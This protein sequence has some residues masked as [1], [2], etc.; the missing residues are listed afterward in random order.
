MYH[1]IA[2]I[3]MSMIFVNLLIWF[4]FMPWYV[5]RKISRIQNDIV[6]RHYDE[7]KMTYQNMRGW[8]HDFHNHVQ[9][10][11]AH[12]SLGQYEEAKE[13]LNGLERDLS[14]IDTT[15]KTGNVTA[16]A[17]LNS[18]LTMMKAR[19]IRVD[20]TAAVPED[21]AISGTDLCILIGNMLDNAIEACMKMP[22]EERYIRIYI[23]IIKKQFYIVVTNSMEGRARRE[24]NRYI[25]SKNTDG[26]GFGLLRIDR[27][28]E[29]YHGYLNRKNE[30]GVF[31]TEVMLPLNH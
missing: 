31:A 10:L 11:K 26:H 25:S 17:I 27:V 19:A 9:T 5:D 20:A 23:D 30:N 28:V 24:G 18:K 7:V 13:Y 12:M 14:V 16:D 4:I 22:E 6:N 29:K 2:A 21:I 8:R 15:L 1:I 3:A